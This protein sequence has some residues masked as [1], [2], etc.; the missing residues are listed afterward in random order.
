METIVFENTRTKETLARSLPEGN[1]LEENWSGNMIEMWAEAIVK[2]EMFTKNKL[3]SFDIESLLEL[4]PEELKNFC[5]RVREEK[6]NIHFAYFD[7]T[8]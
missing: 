5:E 3:A 2:G 1:F 4:S 6:K 7:K 8:E